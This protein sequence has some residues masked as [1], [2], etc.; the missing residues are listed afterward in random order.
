M[1]TYRSTWVSFKT[2]QQN[3]LQPQQIHQ[4]EEQARA[5]FAAVL[6][7]YESNDDGDPLWLFGPET[8]PTLLDAHVVPFIARLLDDQ[9][10]RDDLVPPALQEYAARVRQTGPA[11]EEATRGR[12]TMWS[13]G[14]GHAHLMVL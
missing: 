8:G 12:P 5:F 2:H 14:L 4:A 13:V 3:E 9:L 6:N 7:V 1:L 10:K 11:W